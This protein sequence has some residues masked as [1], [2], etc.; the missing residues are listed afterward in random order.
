MSCTEAH[1]R[2]EWYSWPPVNR[3]GVGRPFCAQDGA[4]GAAADRL[5]HRLDPL[6]A[7]RPLGD[8]DDLRERRRRSG[9]CWGTAGGRSPRRA[10]AAPSAAIRSAVRR[11]RATC[12]ASS[13]SSKSRAMKRISRVPGVARELV[14]V[15]E[16]LAVARRLRRERV[17][18]Q[19]GEQP[20]GQPRGVDELALGPARVDVDA[21]EDDHDLGAGERLVLDLARAGSRRACR[22]RRRRSA[23][24]RTAWRPRRSPR[25]A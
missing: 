7:D 25:R 9:A 14:R 19:L 3:F 13:A 2:T 16:A 4:V 8:L 22:R 1:S 17:R 12:S 23:R 15:D 18:R 21:L 11:I 24:R 20:P 5:A 10:S 6:R